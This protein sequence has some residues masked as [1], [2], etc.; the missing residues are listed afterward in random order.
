MTTIITYPQRIIGDYEVI[1]YPAHSSGSACYAI[2][3]RQESLRAAWETLTY[4][5]VDESIDAAREWILDPT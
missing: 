5:T 3:Y 4:N 1:V 2:V